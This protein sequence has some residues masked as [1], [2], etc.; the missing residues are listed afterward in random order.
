MSKISKFLDSVKKHYRADIASKMLDLSD[1]TVFS[2]NC[3]GGVMYHDCHSR[4]LSPTVNLFFSA[5]DFLKFV[6][7][8]EYYFS[9]PLKF[10]RAEGYPVGE[11]PDGLRIYFMHY[12]SEEEAE[13]KWNERKQR[14]NK[15]KIF[16]ICTDRDGFDKDDFKCFKSLKY[17]KALFTVNP[18]YKDDSECIYIPKYK[19][20][21]CLPDLIPCRDMYYKY[22]L[23]KM[24]NKA[25]GKTNESS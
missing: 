11:F 20:N 3:I 6:E 22:R 23:P 4:F 15:N 5:S 16:I 25:Y 19:D 1:V 24:I 18:E 14:V 10:C 21:S 7:K 8:Y 9:Q 13:K 12:S 2:Q 17:P